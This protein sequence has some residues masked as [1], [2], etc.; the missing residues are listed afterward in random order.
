[1]D[2]R[3]LLTPAYHGR[4]FPF[5]SRKL[6]PRTSSNHPRFH[7]FR[8]FFF[9][10]FWKGGR[11]G[12]SWTRPR[13]DDAAHVPPVFGGRASRYA[14]FHGGKKSERGKGEKAERR[15][16]REKKERKNGERKKETGKKSTH[17]VLA[18]WPPSPLF[19]RDEEVTSDRPAIVRIYSKLL[20]QY[21]LS[22]L[23]SPVSFFFF[24]SFFFVLFS[25]F[26]PPLLPLAT[27]SFPVRSPFCARALPRIRLRESRVTRPAR[28]TSK[29]HPSKRWQA[30]AH[31]PKRF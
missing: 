5:L 26:S 13:L 27:L 21:I 19:K 18:A 7:W 1:M 3:L 20:R 12:T 25:F 2:L 14:F 9:L 22:V 8:F 31:P 6:H 10:F 29:L 23:F 11:E 24:P 30:G 17:P 4:I 28:A 15:T 16:E